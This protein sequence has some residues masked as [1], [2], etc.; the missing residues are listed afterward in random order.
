VLIVGS[1]MSYHNMTSFMTP[2]A[3]SD[4]EAFDAWLVRSVAE[5]PPA[6]DHA[7]EHWTDAP[8]ARA[9]HPREEHLLPLMVVAGAGEA[10]PGRVVFRD[11]VMGSTVSAVR[12]G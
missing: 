6:R 9:C 1:G 7:L 4:S 11:V 8:R 2:A 3:G 10:D 12:F 5:A